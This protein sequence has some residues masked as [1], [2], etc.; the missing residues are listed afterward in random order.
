MLGVLVGGSRRHRRSRIHRVLPAPTRRTSEVSLQA[1]SASS[2]CRGRRRRLDQPTSPRRLFCGADLDAGATDRGGVGLVAGNA[3]AGE[4]E[5]M[6]LLPSSPA[7][8]GHRSGAGRHQQHV[9]E[10]FP[11]LVVSPSSSSGRWSRSRSRCSPGGRRPLPPPR[12]GA[13]YGASSARRS[14]FAPGAIACNGLDVE[15]LLVDEPVRF[16]FLVLANGRWIISLKW[17]GCHCCEPGASR[18]K[19]PG[20]LAL[21]FG[22]YLDRIAVERSATRTRRRSRPSRFRSRPGRRRTVPNQSRRPL[23]VHNPKLAQSGVPRRQGTICRH[24]AATV[25]ASYDLKPA[26]HFLIEGTTERSPICAPRTG[27][28][29][30]G[31]VGIFH[32]ILDRLAE[33]L[34]M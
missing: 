4:P 22:A 3:A 16:T 13:G 26:P 20:R 12:C 15:G 34:S 33:S 8:T 32:H 14:T 9:V 24:P 27:T 17:P 29:R 28:G 7:E 5:T 25:V 18:G 1:D 2:S 31:T 11:R 19:P 10:R 23:V 21:V 30:S 6:K